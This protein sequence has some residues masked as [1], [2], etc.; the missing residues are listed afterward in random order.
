M[1]EPMHSLFPAK[2]LSQ[3]LVPQILEMAGFLIL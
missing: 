3:L 2:A 1:S